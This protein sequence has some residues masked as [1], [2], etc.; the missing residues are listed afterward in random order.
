MP[1][2]KTGPYT[3]ARRKKWLKNAKGYWGAKSRLYKSARLQVM[4]AW[5]SAYKERRRKKRVFRALA[6][7]RINAGLAPF[8]ISYSKFIRGLKLAGTEL[9]RTV[10]AELAVQAPEDFGRLVE[11]AKEQLTAAPAG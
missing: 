10:V 3:R 2:V 1:R 4:H 5:M 6:V 8:G 11:L 9:D 7:T